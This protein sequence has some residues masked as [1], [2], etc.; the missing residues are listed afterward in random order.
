MAFQNFFFGFVPL[1]G[2]PDGWAPDC[3][4]TIWTSRVFWQSLVDGSAELQVLA[5]RKVNSLI[6]VGLRM[7]STRTRLCEASSL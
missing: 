4:L 7:G 2:D 5:S 6:R 3:L 1:L